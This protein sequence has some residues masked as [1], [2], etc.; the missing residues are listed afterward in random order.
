MTSYHQQA[1][2]RA[3]SLHWSTNQHINYIDVN[4]S[5]KFRYQVH[6]LLCVVSTS[7]SFVK[8][9][10]PEPEV[11]T[12]RDIPKGPANYIIEVEVLVLLYP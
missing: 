12:I 3:A 7:G 10:T 1:A 11:E 5:L 8:P 2:G 4:S 6:R 9:V